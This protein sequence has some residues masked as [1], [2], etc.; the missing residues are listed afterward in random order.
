MNKIP[1]SPFATRLS[2]SATETELRIRSIFQ[3]KKQRPPLWAMILTGLVILSCGGLVSCQIQEERPAPGGLS[4]DP[5]PAPVSR[6]ADPSLPYDLETVSLDGLTL[7]DSGTEDDRVTVTSCRVDASDREGLTTVEVTLGGGQTA[8]WEHPFPCFPNIVPLHLTSPDVQSLVIEMADRTSN[9]GAARYFI[10]EMEDGALAERGHIGLWDDPECDLLPDEA[11][12]YGAK[13]AEREDSALQ[14]LRVPVLID[15]W[16]DPCYITLTW[17]DGQFVSK[18]DDFFTDRETLPLP[19]GGEVT[20]ELEGRWENSD[21][22]RQTLYYSEIRVL[23]GTRLLQTITPPHALPQPRAFDSD[24]AAQVT[25]PAANAPAL[26]FS[27]E[28]QLHALDLRD[29]NFDGFTDLGLPWDTTHNDVHLW[30]L[31]DPVAGQFRYSFALQGD[32]T[33]DAERHLLIETRW[34]EGPH[35]YS[36]NARGQICWQGP[37]EM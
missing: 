26:G 21:T 10:L 37:Y 25:P 9:Y 7:D 11:V 15:K 12:L 13:W 32:L 22:A 6:P 20:I 34:E 33:I 3:W 36:F 35:T 8:V 16:H 28:S 18:A 17:E 2:G 1:S 24:T 4:G 27:A 30:Y 31:W 5:G 23:E 29:A 19:D 14:A